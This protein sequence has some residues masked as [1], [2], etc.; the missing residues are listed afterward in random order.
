MKKLR[1]LR[2]QRAQALLKSTQL[3]LNDISLAVGYKD[4]F[5]FSSAFKR[6]FGISPSVFRRL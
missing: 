3:N 4:V 2:M 1:E 5:N 6:I